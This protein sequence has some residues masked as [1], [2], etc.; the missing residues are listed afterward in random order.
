MALSHIALE[1]RA[2]SAKARFLHRPRDCL[3]CPHTRVKPPC[4]KR[5]PPRYTAYCRFGIAQSR[6]DWTPNPPTHTVPSRS[7]RR[8]AITCPSTSG[9]RLSVAPFQLTRPANV[10]IHRVPSRARANY[11]CHSGRV[12]T[13]RRL[14]EDT[15]V[16][17]SK[18]NKPNSRAEPEI[19]IGRLG[20]RVDAPFEE[21]VSDGPRGMRILADIERRIERKRSSAADQS[22]ARQQEYAHVWSERCAHWP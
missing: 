6:A 16:T 2:S 9:Y 21:P 22:G 3:S 1:V 7:S 14:P 4:R 17:P 19:P 10:P 20:H 11:E 8:D 18:R 5:H 13:R 15:V 12:L